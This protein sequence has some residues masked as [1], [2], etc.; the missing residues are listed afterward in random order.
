MKKKKPDLILFSLTIFLTLFGIIMVYNASVFESYQLFS[1]KYH[2]LKL[3][4]IWSALGFLGLCATTFIS[5]DFVK[6]ISPLALLINI[7]LLI[8]VLIPGLS[9]KSFGARRWI[10]IAGFNLQPTELIKLVLSIYLAA[11][12][13]KKR[14]FLPFLAILGFILG[15]IML[16]PDLGTSIVIILIGVIVYYIS[17]AKLTHL[18]ITGLI[19]G[20]SGIG[21]ILSSPYRKARLLTFFDPSADPLGSSYHITQALIAIGSGGLWGLGLGQSRQ[22]YQFLPQVTTDSIFA[23]ISEEIGFIGASLLILA[24]FAFIQ[25]GFRIA[26]RAKDDFS[27]LLAV[28]IS[29]WIG[30]Q[31]I[32]N[33]GAMLAL[34]PLTG[35]P[36]PFISYGGSSMIVILTGV[37]LLL[38][39]SRHQVS[40]KKR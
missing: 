6:K 37:G 9:D 12:L 32:I 20:L 8:I 29:G 14:N 11:W 18:I 13:A 16:Q 5:L 40:P 3:Q 23:I 7:I 39:I 35:V 30:I 22:K 1:D 15:L 4:A 34:L 2:F 38:N 26:S 21:L 27:K 10:S 28:G 33:L 31:T 24:L 19:G 36:L 25:R 17:G